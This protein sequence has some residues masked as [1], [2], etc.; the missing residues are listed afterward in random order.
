LNSLTT[1][2]DVCRF[3]AGN[4][5]NFHTITISENALA[6]HLARGLLPDSCNA[7]CA[8]NVTMRMHVPWTT[9]AAAGS[10]ERLGSLNSFA[11]I[12]K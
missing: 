7:R 11:S 12:A 1:T 2:F 9:R 8:D 6:A 3:P 5:D 4:L 10:T